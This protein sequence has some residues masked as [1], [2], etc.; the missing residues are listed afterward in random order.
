MGHT[1]SKDGLSPD[2]S[3]TVVL[4]SYPMPNDL[5]T[6]HSFLGLESYF[7]RFIQGFSQIATPLFHLLKKEVGADTNFVWSSD[8]Q[9]A[10][11]KL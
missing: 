11:D 1:I 9:V 6:L 3:K 2:K 4:E 8:C 5:K 7:R 10:F